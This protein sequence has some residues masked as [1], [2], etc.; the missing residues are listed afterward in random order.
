MKKT[1]LSHSEYQVRPAKIIRTR[2]MTQSEKYFEIALSEGDSLEHDPGQFVMVS[3]PKVGEAPISISSSPTKR[4]AFELVVRKAGRLT[5]ALHGLEEGDALG[6]RGPFGKGF[7]VQILEGN[8]LIFVAGGLGL[9]PLRSL[10][11]FVIDNRRDFG[12]VTILL[13]CKTPKDL[14][15]SDELDGW[16]KRLDLAFNCTVDKSDEDWKGNVGLITSLIPGV[17]LDTDRTFAV[18]VGPP[19]MYKFVL[20]ELLKKNIPERQILVSLERHMKC[21]VGKCGHCQ[22]QN[23]YCCQDGPVFTYEQIKGK[24]EAL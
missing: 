13:G 2:M 16:S 22:I 6:I 14:L 7:P 8:D 11:N 15:F 1:K 18:V 17:T 9:V 19:V 5:G 10:I 24:K 20:I 12:K 3:I 4:G 23:Y 21:G